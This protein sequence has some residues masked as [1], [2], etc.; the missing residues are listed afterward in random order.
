VLGNIEEVTEPT[1]PRGFPYSERVKYS[2]WSVGD[3]VRATP[4][5]N[6]GLWQGVF[7]INAVDKVALKQWSY[8]TITLPAHNVLVA[9]GK[10]I[11]AC[12]MN[13]QFRRRL[14]PAIYQFP[15]NVTVGPQC[16]IDRYGDI[17]GG[18]LL[19]TL[20]DT[21]GDTM[22]V[23]RPTIHHVKE[24]NYLRN[25]WQENLAHTVNDEFIRVL[26]E[27]ASEL[28]PG[29]YLDMFAQLH[30]S[31]MERRVHCSPVLRAYFTH[32]GPCLSAW[33]D[34]LRLRAN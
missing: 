18:F 16:V 30:E 11:S 25:I 21:V 4:S 9:K 28:T 24:G 31:F 15:M 20:M 2:P 7:D 23:G 13:M 3:T 26:T 6:L 1:F 32:L 10:L 14:A 5:F 17:W 22:T 19:K 29:P 34:A 33:I 12:S 8:P 27:A